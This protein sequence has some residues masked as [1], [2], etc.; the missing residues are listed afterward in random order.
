MK[1][2]KEAFQELAAKEERRE[3]ADPRLWRY[4][5][6][7]D[8]RSRHLEDALEAQQQLLQDTRCYCGEEWSRVNPIM[9]T[10]EGEV[11]HAE[12][13]YS[14]GAVQGTSNP[15]SG[16]LVATTEEEET[17]EVA[18]EEGQADNFPSSSEDTSYSAQFATFRSDR[19]LW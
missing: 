5:G 2:A 7:Q 19:Y 13:P 4:I 6:E 16:T 9:L 1:G 3:E 17:D 12:S 10:E 11:D 8:L 15:G 18:W 14:I